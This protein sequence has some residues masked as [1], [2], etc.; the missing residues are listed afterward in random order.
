MKKGDTYL[1]LPFLF[2]DLRT[3]NERIKYLPL[4]SKTLGYEFRFNS[5]T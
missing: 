2:L 4:R 3:Q 1:C 5:G